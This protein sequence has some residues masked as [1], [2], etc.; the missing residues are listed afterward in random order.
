[1]SW[2]GFDPV[3]FGSKALNVNPTA[4]EACG[5][6]CLRCC[7]YSKGCICIVAHGQTNKARQ[8]NTLTATEKA[9]KKLC[10][11]AAEVINKRTIFCREKVKGKITS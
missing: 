1:M 10:K 3:T 2:P 9:I 11:R 8:R 6:D 7:T 4:T 5:M